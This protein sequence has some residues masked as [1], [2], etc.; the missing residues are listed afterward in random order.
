[1]YNGEIEDMINEIMLQLRPVIDGQDAGL[2]LAALAGVM[3]RITMTGLDCDEATAIALV[4]ALFR[5]T[6]RE[7][8]H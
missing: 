3:M 8:P 4:A 5:D 6:M 7:F 2:V 1:M